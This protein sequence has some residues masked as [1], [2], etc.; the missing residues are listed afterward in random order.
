MEPDCQAF[1]RGLHGTIQHVPKSISCVLLA[2]ISGKSGI[3]D[4]IQFVDIQRFHAPI[5]E[6]L[7]AAAR[8]V[9]DGGKYIGGEEVKGFEKEMAAWLEVPEVCGVACATSGLFAAMKCL[10]IGP[11]DEVITTVH[12]AIATAE[13]I[14]L[15]GARAVFVDIAPGTFHLDPAQVEEVIPC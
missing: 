9:I 1:G 2:L 8:R 3:M 12:T 13:A 11:G 7:H 14:T 5:R 4:T 10:G 15:T 6:A